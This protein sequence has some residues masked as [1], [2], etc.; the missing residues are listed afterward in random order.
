MPIG[1]FASGTESPRVRSIAGFSK[2]IPYN[3]TKSSK[4]HVPPKRDNLITKYPSHQKTQH[5]SKLST[6]LLRTVAFIIS[7]LTGGNV[8][9]KTYSLTKEDSAKWLHYYNTNIKPTRRAFRSIVLSNNSIAIP[10]KFELND[11]L[12]TLAPM[13]QEQRHATSSFENYMAAFVCE[14]ITKDA[15]G[16]SGSNLE[17]HKALDCVLPLLGFDY[18]GP[19]ITADLN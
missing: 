17:I 14:V 11:C 12:L 1:V 15:S 5:L 19:R 7:S 18:R 9:P 8:L 10:L 3:A 16:S 13:S 2:T 6:S 4:P